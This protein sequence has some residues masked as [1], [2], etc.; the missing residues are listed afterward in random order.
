[1]LVSVIA[2]VSEPSEGYVVYEDS[3]RAAAGRRLDRTITRLRE[4]G[5]PALGHVFDTTR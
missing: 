1:M 5:I 4:A 3:R 2:P